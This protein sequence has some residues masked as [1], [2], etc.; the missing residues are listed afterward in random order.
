MRLAAPRGP[1][2]RV[3]LGITLPHRHGDPTLR[4]CDEWE[5]QLEVLLVVGALVAADL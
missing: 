1:L 2:T 3:L 5:S 4:R